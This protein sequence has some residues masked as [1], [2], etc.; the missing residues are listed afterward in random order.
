MEKNHKHMILNALVRSPIVTEE[1]CKNWLRKL[2]EIIDMKILI[3]PV[4]KFCDT[5][6]N[7]GVTGTVVIETSHASIHVW[8]K[9][10]QPVIKM[11]VYSCKDFD[12]DAVVNLVRETMDIISCAYMIVDRNSVMPEVKQIGII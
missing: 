5:E 2:V 7:E 6:G 9:E 12:P 8:H 11:D 10:E 1:S 4:A 3:E